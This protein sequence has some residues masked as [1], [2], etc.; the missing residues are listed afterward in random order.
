MTV[1]APDPATPSVGQTDPY[2]WA[3]SSFRTPRPADTA[4]RAVHRSAAGAAAQ[5]EGG[6]PGRDSS[7]QPSD[8]RSAPPGVMI[9]LAANP[10]AAVRRA[11]VGLA[12][13]IALLVLV[14]GLVVAVLGAV[15]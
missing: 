8:T 9:A 2:P 6:Q 5:D 12:R 10:A 4:A 14:I 7:R 1:G 11:P 13:A 15:S 3:S